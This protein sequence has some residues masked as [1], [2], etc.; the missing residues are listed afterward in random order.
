[1]E[2]ILP[3]L[4]VP[5]ILVVLVI[6]FL[7]GYALGRWGL[8]P[9]ENTGEAR[10]RQVL[11]TYFQPP[12]YHLLNNITL[13]FEDGTTQID[14][15]L[16]ST[17]GIFVI[18][19]K[20]YSGELLANEKSPA[21]TQVL[22]MAKM[23]MPN[24]IRQNYRHVRVVR[25]LLDFIPKEH[26]HS[27]VV[28]TGDAV[29]KTKIPEGVMYLSALVEHINLFQEEVINPEKFQLTI[30]RLECIRYEI[31]KQTD[32]EHKAYLNRKY[33]ND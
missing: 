2:A 8:R 16:V 25:D 10:V 22:R 26:V 31:S 27:L 7:L 18:E 3:I 14:H 6:I 21:W 4:L 13:P 28:F 19:T 33:G 30:G 20:H 1:M 17:R 24:P 15:I 5:F 29:F 32:V 11:T 23:Q 12:G 9:A